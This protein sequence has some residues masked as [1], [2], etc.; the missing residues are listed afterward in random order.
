M[1]TTFLSLTFDA[2]AGA[3]SNNSGGVTRLAFSSGGEAVA[4]AGLSTPITFSMP[5]SPLNDGQQ[6]TCAWWD[7]TA[8]AYNT[9]GCIALPSP[10]PPGHQVAFTPGFVVSGPGSLSLAWNISGPLLSGC[11]EAVLDC[12]NETARGGK[13]QLAAGGTSLGC[14]NSTS[15]V[16]RAFTGADCALSNATGNATCAWDAAAQAFSGSGC[17]A[18]DQTRCACV[19]LT[20]FTSAPAPKLPVAS[21]AD[22]F[23]YSAADIVTKLRL[24]FILVISLFGALHVG[25]GIALLLDRRER[26]RVNHVLCDEA[27]GFRVTKGGAWVWRFSLDALPEGVELAAPSGPA[28]ELAAVLGMPV[29][30]RYGYRGTLALVL[31]S[32]LSILQ[33]ASLRACALHCRTRSSPVT[34]APRW[35]AATASAPRT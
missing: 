21:L 32:A 26:A 5:A 15:V 22:M 3:R 4:V 31:T 30:S 8:A 17:V 12:S 29:R 23:S 6:T 2:H 35:A 9:T 18:A 11:V 27:C 20:D 24:L 10:Y 34:S 13:L 25:G 19:H 33:P 1:A 14:G 7:D 28:V 16:L